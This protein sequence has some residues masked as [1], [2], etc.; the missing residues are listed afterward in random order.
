MVCQIIGLSSAATLF[1]ECFVLAF[2]YLLCV[3]LAQSS[4]QLYNAGKEDGVKFWKLWVWSFLW[5]IRKMCVDIK[6]PDFSSFCILATPK[7]PRMN[8]SVRL[9]EVHNV[10]L[11][12]GT[13]WH[14]IDQSHK[15]SKHKLPF[16]LPSP[17]WTFAWDGPFQRCLFPWCLKNWDV[18]PTETSHGRHPARCW[19]PGVSQLDTQLCCG[20]NRTSLKSPAHCPA[21]GKASTTEV[22]SGRILRI[23]YGC[24]SCCPHLCASVYA[25]LISSNSTVSFSSMKVQSANIIKK[26]ENL[27]EEEKPEQSRL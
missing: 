11:H 15:R 1:C 7:L 26:K 10:Y 18:T 8:S 13:W 17:A 14:L 2:S 3:L 24:L 9:R 25:V 22:P 27:P 20:W 19:R 5:C 6:E 4:Y 21:A 12:L 23:R 16:S